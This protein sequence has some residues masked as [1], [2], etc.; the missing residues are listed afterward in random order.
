MDIKDEIRQL[1]I[2]VMIIRGDADIY[3]N[4]EISERLHKDIKNSQLERIKTG[5]HLIQE[6][7]PELLISLIIDFSR[8]TLLSSSS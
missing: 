2:P 8:K 4:S 5:G 6:D 3:L 7:E 1:K